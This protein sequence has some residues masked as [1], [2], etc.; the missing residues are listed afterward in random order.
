[1]LRTKTVFEVGD[2]HFVLDPSI[3]GAKLSSVQLQFCLIKSAKFEIIALMT[4][5]TSTDLHY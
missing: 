5:G 2:H 4:P 1:M 3:K